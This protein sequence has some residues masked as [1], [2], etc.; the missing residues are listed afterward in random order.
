M[1]DTQ[2]RSDGTLGH[3]I[4][5]QSDPAAEERSTLAL[6]SSLV[7]Q[8]REVGVVVSGAEAAIEATVVRGTQPGGDGTIGTGIHVQD[9]PETHER[10]MAF[11][12][13]T[14]VDQN[15]SAGVAVL[16]SDAVVEATVVRGTQPEGDGTLGRGIDIERGATLALR[17]STIEQNHEAGVVVF[18]S[19]ATVEATVVRDTRSLRDGSFGDGIAV[20]SRRADSAAAVTSSNVEANGRAGISSFGSAVAV[21]SSV[22]RCNK[23]DLNGNSE[24]SGRKFTFGGSERNA[25]GC[26][27]PVSP[28][29]VESANVS[30][31]E[32]IEPA[33]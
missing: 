18:D 33:M 32:P 6:R 23:L 5:I 25:C 16:G 3:G 20:I 15:H 4:G 17:A 21:V 10:G 24:E 31:P 1:R 11:I 13:A 9:H 12:R 26:E 29:P 2:P 14:L 7:E 8:N 30:P 19:Q 22:V 27:T 28:C